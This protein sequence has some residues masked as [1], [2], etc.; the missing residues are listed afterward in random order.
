MI[1]N[2]IK[3]HLRY[4]NISPRKVRMVANMI[5]GLDVVNA[6]K[7]LLFS[8]RRSAKS[9]LKLLKHGIDVAEKQKKINKE[10]LFIKNIVV[11][12]GPKQKRYRAMSR[13]H[14]GRI[15]KRTSHI[16]LELDKKNG[17]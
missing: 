15:I 10:N 17:T 9:L 6:E 14:V 4:L 2:M 1:L 3:V 7:Q 5:K 8:S 13:G 12:E 16:T 11:N